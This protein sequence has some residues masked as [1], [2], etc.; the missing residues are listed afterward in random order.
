MERE[1]EAWQVLRSNK[2]SE[3]AIVL[4]QVQSLEPT[5]NDVRITQQI[6]PL[7]LN[8]VKNTALTSE[9]VKSFKHVSFFFSSSSSSSSSLLTL[10]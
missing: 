2:T 1:R 10:F 8:V 4:M 6:R 5:L 9:T 7:N 3:K